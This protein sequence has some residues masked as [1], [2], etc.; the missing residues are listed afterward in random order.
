MPSFNPCFSGLCSATYCVV[1]HLTYVTH[2]SIL[3]LVDY[4]L[5]LEVTGATPRYIV[6]FN[7]CFSGLCS[8]TDWS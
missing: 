3:V 5:Q 7:P 6:S 4:A 2:V 8:A 1:S